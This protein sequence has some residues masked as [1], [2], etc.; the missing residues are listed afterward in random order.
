MS[1]H[2]LWVTPAYPPF[3]GGGERYVRSL[4]HELVK[5]GYHITILT[6]TAEKESDFWQGSPHQEVQ[7]TADGPVRIIRCPLRPLAGGWQML[8]VWRTLMVA[9]SLFSPLPLSWLHKMAQFVPAIQW[10]VELHPL[11]GQV[12]LIHA[13]NISWEHG[14]LTGRVWAEQE[15]IPYV[16][17]PFA[18]LSTGPA[19]RVTRNS[20][21]R[22]QL[23]VL[24]AA[25]LVLTLTT[26]EADGLAKLGVPANQIF[27]IGSGGDPLP[28]PLPP[29]LPLPYQQLDRPLVLFL[30]RISFDKGAH[31][32]VQ[33][34]QQLRQEGVALSLAL[35]GQPAPEFTR[36]FNGLSTTQKEGICLFGP[37]DELYKHQLL[38]AAEVLALPSRTDSFGLVFLEAW[39][40]G[41]PVIG[42][43]AGGIPGVVTHEQDGLLV[44]YGDITQLR[45]A[46]RRLVNDAQLRQQ[47]G[48]NGHITREFRFTWERVA[49]RVHAVY[50]QIL[51][52][53]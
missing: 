13:F 19:D 52:K 29:P 40:Y 41:K 30:G 32:L 50:Q 42:A 36:F 48:R 33:A 8:R 20:T 6:S 31:H 14:L 4:A 1:Q 53:N 46:L 39:A 15:Q 5:K 34:V 22:H 45:E 12:D 2:L 24:Q 18:H 9:G 3:Q 43:R 21:M 17:T 38:Q 10:P 37:V 47:L 11:V 35:A 23:E 44:E 25:R 26:V 28:D 27:A 7:Q 51:K 49:G 16:A